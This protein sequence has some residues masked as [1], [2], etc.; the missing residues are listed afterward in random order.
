[1]SCKKFP[2]LYSFRRC[3]YAMRTRLVLRSKSEY[4]ELREIKLQNKPQEFL[5]ITSLGTVPV[6]VISNKKVLLESLD[7]I[8]WCLKNSEKVIENQI[9]KIH[10]DKKWKYI[11]NFDTIFKHNLDRYKYPT[12]FSSI[13]PIV[14]RK[15]NI[16]FLKNLNERLKNSKFLFDDKIDF[17]DYCIFPFIR[18]FR[19]VNV[20]WFENLNFKFLNNWFSIIL[21]SDEFKSIMKKHKIWESTDKPIITNFKYN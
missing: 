17:A 19:N 15:K 6:L 11:E 18:Q 16:P 7:I 9:Q 4:V 3:P 1:M 2:I 13:D 8:R 21:E 14:Y 10:D 20:E 12:R 5:K